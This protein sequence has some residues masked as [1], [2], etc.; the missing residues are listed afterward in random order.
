MNTLCIRVFVKTSLMFMVCQTIHEVYLK[1]PNRIKEGSKL[2]NTTLERDIRIKHSLKMSPC[3]SDIVRKAIRMLE[4]TRIRLE[5][6][7]LSLY[8]AIVCL[9]LQKYMHFWSA[10]S[11]R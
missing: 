8:K 5:N 9:H 11:H 2:A 10:A 1:K 4:V 3:L 7:I 6:K